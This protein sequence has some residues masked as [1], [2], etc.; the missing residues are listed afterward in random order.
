MFALIS[1]RG[2]YY[3]GKAG[4]QFVSPY[5]TEAFTWTVKSGAEQKC[6]LLNKWSVLNGHKFEVMEVQ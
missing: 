1:E 2:Y 3:T 6:E 5:L 4:E